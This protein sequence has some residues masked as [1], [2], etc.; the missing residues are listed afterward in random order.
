VAGDPYSLPPDLP[1][2]EDDGAAAHLPGT[3]PPA[4]ALPASDG[5]TIDLAA[6]PGRAVVFA[7][8][9]T[10]VPGV[11][12]GD[13]WDA[14]PG[15]RGCTPEMC[16]V[17]DDFGAFT[18]RGVAVF[19]L[20]AQSLDEVTEAAGRLGLPYP[21]LSDAAGELADALRLP[22]IDWQGRRLIKRVTLLL[23]DGAIEDVIYPVFPPDGAAAA[24]LAA[25]D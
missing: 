13:D 24:A 3:R 14:I 12:P 21:L 4:V 11:D 2:P 20:S 16:A 9:R 5:S 17:R 8:P 23:R 22:T 15:A 10:G 7:Y 19:G 25:L 6:V 1:V 18:E